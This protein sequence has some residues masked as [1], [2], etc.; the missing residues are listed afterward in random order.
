MNKT[1]KKLLSYTLGAILALGLGL[2]YAYAVGANDSNAFVTTTEWEAKV[3]QIEAS[4]DNVTKTINDSNMD[5]VMNAPRLQ[6]SLVEGF[7]N[8]GGSPFP[9][10]IFN[11]VY[12]ES[13][14]TST[15]SVYH[16]YNQLMI[17]DSWDGRQ[18]LLTSVGYPNQSYVGTIYGCKAR[19]ALRSNDPN[20]YLIVSIYYIGTDNY[21]AVTRAYQVNYVDISKVR[22]DYT[23]AKTV[24]VELPLSE[25]AIPVSSHLTIPAQGRTSTNTYTGTPANSQFP[26]YLAG[27]TTNTD[28]IY[29]VSNP[30]TGYSKR[31]VTATDVIFTFDF[32]AGTSIIRQLM[33]AAP[34]GTWDVLP[35][36]MNG[37]KFGGAYDYISINSTPTLAYTSAHAI[38]KVY[39]PQKGCLCLKNYVN[40][41]IPIF[42]E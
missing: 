32:P 31:D 36:N 12:R 7:E 11:S 3:A 17:Q 37:R 22:Q 39:S 42:N 15:G 6:T 20:V 26:P 38:A 41:E 18:T 4:L 30:A 19:F 21:Q 1:F 34:W 2:S 33:S 29:P 8:N 40:G 23:A 13:S 28:N 5:F 10:A 14:T 35:V 25:W 24:V 27:V 9:Y 16:N